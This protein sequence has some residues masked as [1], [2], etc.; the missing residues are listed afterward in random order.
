MVKRSRSAPKPC[1]RCNALPVIYESEAGDYVAICDHGQKSTRWACVAYGCV[2]RSHAI[3]LWNE[4]QLPAK[5]G[6]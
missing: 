1:P 2:S 3:Q 5:R 6:R 4:I